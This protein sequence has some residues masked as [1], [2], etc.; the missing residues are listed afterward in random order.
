MDRLTKINAIYAMMNETG[1]DALEGM[2]RQ[3]LRSFPNDQA[4][5]SLSIVQ[6]ADDVELLDDQPNC[7]VYDF[8]LIGVRQPVDGQKA[9]VG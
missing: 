5:K 3:L 7:A 9:D 4:K 8:P 6:S 1:Q 2:A